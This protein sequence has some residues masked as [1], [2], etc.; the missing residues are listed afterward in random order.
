MSSDYISKLIENLNP[1]IKNKNLNMVLDGGCFNGGYLYGALLYIKNLERKNLIKINKIS[2]TS[3]GA[4]I[5]TLYII[6]NL[7]L[8][9]SI[10]EIIREKFKTKGSLTCILKIIKKI[11]KKY[12][13]EDFYKKCNNK[14]YITYFNI[15]TKKQIIKKTYKNNDDLFQTLI[16]SSYIPFL[17]GKNILY[18][19]KYFDGITPFLFK[20]QKHTK[21]LYLN[22]S[23]YQKEIFTTSNQ[24]NIYSRMINGI[25]ETHSFFINGKK[26]KIC[27][28]I[29]N[30]TFK[31]QINIYFKGYFIKGLVYILY[32][33]LILYN[34]LPKFIFKIIKNNLILKFI[35]KIL[36]NSFIEIFLE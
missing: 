35:F 14:L 36:K 25:I 13:E 31:E 10:Y 26:T 15:Q 4:L 12:I 34:L 22:L 7:E 11:Q 16:K 24:K 8:S 1:Q 19:N 28:Y 33:I 20:P 21:T 6:D 9:E 2:G 5:A 32:V 23:N 17:N 3:V 29:E 30:L 18:K 27:N